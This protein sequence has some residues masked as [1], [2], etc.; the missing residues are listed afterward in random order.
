MNA[1][2]KNKKGEIRSAGREAERFLDILLTK[3]SDVYK[4]TRES[5][6][7]SGEVRFDD[8]ALVSKQAAGP[9]DPIQG[10]AAASNPA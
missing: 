7:P 4:L 1:P 5:R 9:D 3:I 10:T 8:Y 6:D 2:E